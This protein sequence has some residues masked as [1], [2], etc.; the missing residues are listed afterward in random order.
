MDNGLGDVSSEFYYVGYRDPGGSDPWA[1]DVVY[2]P[3][4][5]AACRG[6]AGGEGEEALRRRARIEAA[7]CRTK[8]LIKERPWLIKKPAFL[9]PPYFSKPLIW[10][11]EA[12]L[13]RNSVTLFAANDIIRDRQRFIM[14]S[15]G[16]DVE[17]TALLAG[18]E[19]R[20]GFSGSLRLTVTQPGDFLDLG[21][22]VPLFDDQTPS[23]F[24]PAPP[25]V[26]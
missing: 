14:T 15:F 23:G 9:E 16:I 5:D 20:F 24:V 10:V 8:E 3:K 6:D 17:N 2:D 18:R 1:E 21:Q 11:G 26:P 12:N 4:R 13:L 22:A 19:L 7:I 25:P